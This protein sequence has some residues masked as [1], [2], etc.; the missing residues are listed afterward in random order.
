MTLFVVAKQRTVSSAGQSW[1]FQGQVGP[2]NNR[3][4]IVKDSGK[5]TWSTRVGAGTSKNTA[6][7][8]TTN[9]TVFTLVSEKTGTDETEHPQVP[10]RVETESPSEKLGLDLSSTSILPKF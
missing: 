10:V 1:L 9:L 3:F 6:E 8:I 5:T 2:N 7:Q 4:R